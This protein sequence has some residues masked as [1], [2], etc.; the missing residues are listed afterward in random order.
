[1]GYTAYIQASYTMFS[2]ES[3]DNYFQ[4]MTPLTQ[5]W[6]RSEPVFLCWQYIVSLTGGAQTDVYV[7]PVYTSQRHPYPL[8]VAFSSLILSA[9]LVVTSPVP[10]QCLPQEFTYLCFPT[11]TKCT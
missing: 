6:M 4:D 3:K 10:F 9:V 5:F 7:V 1:M 11:D 2:S 8:V